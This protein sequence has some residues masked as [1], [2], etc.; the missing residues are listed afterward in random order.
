MSQP[1]PLPIVLHADADQLII[2]AVAHLLYG[3]VTLVPP[4]MSLRALDERIRINRH[5]DILLLGMHFG[6]TSALSRI[7]QYV[8]RYTELKILVLTGLGGLNVTQ[9]CLKA[10]ARGVV[11]KVSAKEEL[12]AAIA[13]VHSGGV[14]I[15]PALGSPSDLATPELASVG[16]VT[17]QVLTLARRGMS[18][19]EIAGLLA[20]TTA[21]V[22]HHKAIL[23]RVMSLPP[24]HTDWTVV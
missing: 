12:R 17:L 19:K 9:Q 3:H 21:G 11:A 15:S 2:D 6:G 1:P 5:F 24:G 4:V 8:S 13:E 10:G 22:Q 20:I 14:F 16:E 23:K 18:D 7:R